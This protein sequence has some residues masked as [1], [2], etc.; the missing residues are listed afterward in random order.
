MGDTPFLPS[1]IT[2]WDV[3]QWDVPQAKVVTSWVS[4]YRNR[5]IRTSYSLLWFDFAHHP[6]SYPE[7]SEGF[8]SLAYLAIIIPSFFNSA[9]IS[10][11]RFFLFAAPL[12][13]G[14]ALVGDGFH[15]LF[16]LFRV[17]EV[18]MLYRLQ[19]IVK[20]VDEW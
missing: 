17:A 18:V 16:D 14:F 13:F 10:F 15:R 3:P 4:S 11:P 2:I 1:L 7:R 12:F 6:S 5:M 20:F 19:V 8:S 9:M